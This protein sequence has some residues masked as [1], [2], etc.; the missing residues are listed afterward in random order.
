M[1]ITYALGGDDLEAFACL[2][3]MLPFLWAGGLVLTVR[4]A[5]GDAELEADTGGN[6]TVLFVGPD[7]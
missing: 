6:V 2:G 5:Y 3:L 7:D 1:N 4:C